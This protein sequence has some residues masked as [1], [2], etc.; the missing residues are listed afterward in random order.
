MQKSLSK[1]K[2]NS[3][4][5]SKTHIQTNKSKFLFITL[6]VILLMF[7]ILAYLLITERLPGLVSKGED[8]EDIVE[9]IKPSLFKDIEPGS[10]GSEPDDLQVINNLLYFTA[11]GKLWKSDGTSEGTVFVVDMY[12]SSG[13]LPRNITNSEKGYFYFSSSHTTSDWDSFG[14]WLSK[15]DGT[16][17]GAKIITD[18]DEKR[19]GCISDFTILG[20]HLYFF[21][22]NMNKSGYELWRSDG[23]EAGT[24]LLK[25]VFS[26]NCQWGVY[27]DFPAPGEHLWLLTPFRNSLYFTSMKEDCTWELLKTDGTKES[28]EK[29]FDF[30]Y[31]P[32]LLLASGDNLFI[33]T[34]SELWRS[35]GTELGTD[36]VKNIVLVNDS[37]QS[38]AYELINGD[39]FFNIYHLIHKKQPLKSIGT[40]DF[41]YHP[42]RIYSEDRGKVVYVDTFPS[43]FVSLRD[44]VYFVGDDKVHGSELWK[45][46][47]TEA[48]TRM[49]KDIYPGEKSSRFFGELLVVADKLYFPANDG[50][51]G[52]ELWE[53]DGTGA[54]TRMIMDIVPGEEGSSPRDLVILGDTLF[55]SA[56][57]GIHGRELWSLDISK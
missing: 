45:S 46:D 25:D 13:S 3:A 18:F 28:I 49:V 31:E 33:E 20:D 43:D 37:T 30:E 16:E 53:S 39:L 1:E 32:R 10:V 7:F 15:G 56:D 21:A 42:R 26:D 57:D 4:S 19:K 11:N 36:I 24:I 34:D 2:T 48:G 54:G 40:K 23:T 51:H 27:G 8:Y 35:D 29:I 17:S 41:N 47:G 22:K 14:H 44:E 52:W 55:F 50:I 12:E 9:D 6:E 5:K 38:E